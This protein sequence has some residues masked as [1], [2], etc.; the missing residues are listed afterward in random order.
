MAR[1]GQWKRLTDH[2]A[3]EWTLFG[4]GVLLLAISPL[5]G[6]IPGPGGVIVAGIGLA[7]IRILDGGR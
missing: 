6:A 3:V 4:L 7:M 5:V 1:R 2:P